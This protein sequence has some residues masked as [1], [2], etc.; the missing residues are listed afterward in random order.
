MHLYHSNLVAAAQVRAAP[1]VS[2]E[3]SPMWASGGTSGIGEISHRSRLILNG[4]RVHGPTDFEKW[5][6]E[7]M[8]E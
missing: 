1:S 4:V 8:V 2:V 3:Y 7:A 5:L 6:M